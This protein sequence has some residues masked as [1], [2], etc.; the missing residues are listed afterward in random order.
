[1]RYKTQTDLLFWKPFFN[2]SCR[3]LR[4]VLNCS[5]YRRNNGCESYD[6]KT[7]EYEKTSTK[8]KLAAKQS[9]KRGRILMMS[10]EKEYGSHE[11]R[12]RA[13]KGLGLLLGFGDKCSLSS[14]KII[15]AALLFVLT[16]LIPSTI[17]EW[18]K[19]CFDFYSKRI[20]TSQ[21]PNN[22]LDSR[23]LY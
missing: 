19:I 23:Q 4:S 15:A 5:T 18:A 7:S 20:A 8:G 1:M 11:G 14:P 12:A 16:L 17:G 21:K 13:V 6:P 3:V 22:L 2:F 9:Q 10:N